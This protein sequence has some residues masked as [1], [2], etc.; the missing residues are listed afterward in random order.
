MFALELNAA[1]W[2]K[3]SRS[4]ASRN[5]PHPPIRPLAPWNG[6]LR[7]AVEKSATVAAG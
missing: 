1:Q 3:S 4:S 2:R 7:A 6:K 5:P